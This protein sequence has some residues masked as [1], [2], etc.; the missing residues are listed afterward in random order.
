M[1][2]QKIFLYDI[3]FHAEGGQIVSIEMTETEAEIFQ[4]ILK[5]ATDKLTDQYCGRCE[6]LGK[7]GEYNSD[8]YDYD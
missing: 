5:S 1:E 8:D 2:E 4:R 7:H 6:L 3:G